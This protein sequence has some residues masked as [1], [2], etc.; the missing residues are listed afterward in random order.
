MNN[1][2]ILLVTI[3]VVIVIVA[4]L[5]QNV[6]SRS[7]IAESGSL[8]S[9]DCGHSESGSNSSDGCEKEEYDYVVIGGG[10]AGLTLAYLLKK[11]KKNVVVIE[12]GRNVD[13]DLPIKN[14]GP[15]N[16]LEEQYRSEYF[17]VGDAHPLTQS[18]ST[19]VHANHYDGGRVLGGTS[20]TN[21]TIWWTQQ[22][23]T[24]DQAGGI[25]ADPNYIIDV[26]T[27]LATYHGLP[28]TSG[29]GPISITL[30]QR[31][32]PEPN[33]VVTNPMAV[34]LNAAIQ[35]AYSANYAI[36]IPI[37]PPSLINPNG[38]F[39]TNHIPCTIYPDTLE[40]CSASNG[41]LSRSTGQS[42]DIR[43]NAEV[44]RIKFKHRTAKYVE[45]LQDGKV[46]RIYAKRKMILCAG[47]NTPALLLQNGIGDATLLNS[48][49]I[50]VV[51][52]NP[53]VGKNMKNHI[54]MPFLTT[55]NP[56][57]YAALV[58]YPF[59]WKKITTGG[60]VPEPG[61]PNSADRDYQIGMLATST[62]NICAY[63]LI[64]VNPQSTGQISLSSKD[65]LVPA[66][67]DLNYLDPTTTDRQSM[68]NGITI[69]SQIAQKLNAIDP[70]Y[71][72][73]S[74]IANPNAYVTANT[75][76]FHHWHGQCAVGKVVD[77]KL[78]VIG[79]K[80]L[81]VA[82]LSIFPLTD[83]NTQS[84]GYV[85]GCAAY[86]YLTGDTDISF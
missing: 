57:D 53:E 72:L 24:Y 71:N 44:I 26:Q 36:N 56:A 30:G 20:T 77:E 15:L 69:I 79:V 74:N 32:G 25:F 34:K 38:P 9:R 46:H 78:D 81:M 84:M 80:N 37:T 55:V 52:D 3:I 16:S 14:A 65:P 10:T 28:S 13:D 54:F 67:V 70:T 75:S 51:Y 2:A 68:I 6:R 33:P 85:A 42:L 19:N 4:V 47:Y 1:S 39:L 83:G 40:R 11:A 82:D 7:R 8:N 61:N 5:L 29:N 31:I 49:N 12:A 50:K 41:F 59:A 58:S 17:W 45:Y 43:L 18:T 62:P 63:I 76:A 23:H 22:Q 66:V 60:I 35:N 27:A 21:D 86:T 64:F 73:L 48:L